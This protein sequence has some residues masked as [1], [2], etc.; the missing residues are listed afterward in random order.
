MA[1]LYR[2]ES[3]PLQNHPVRAVIGFIVILQVNLKMLVGPLDMRESF[4]Q[5]SLKVSPRFIATIAM[6][7]IM[8]WWNRFLLHGLPAP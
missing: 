6:A 7:W 3:S 8:P 5:T 1:I 4:G 2:K